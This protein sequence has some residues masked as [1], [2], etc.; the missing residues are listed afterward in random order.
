MNWRERSKLE[1]AT[2]PALWNEIL[3]C[4]TLNIQTKELTTQI[5]HKGITIRQVRNQKYSGMFYSL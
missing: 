1:K 5:F 2:F 4:Y 3:E